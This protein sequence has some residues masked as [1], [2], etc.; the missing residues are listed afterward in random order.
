MP[1]ELRMDLRVP[2]ERAT[3][4]AEAR[5][6]AGL[7][8]LRKKQWSEVEA[9]GMQ[10]VERQFRV[11][12]SQSAKGVAE[13]HWT[14]PEATAHGTRFVTAE[15]AKIHAWLVA[16]GYEWHIYSLNHSETQPRAGGLLS[17]STDF[18]N[19][20]QELPVWRRF[21]RA[22]A[23]AAT[24]ARTGRAAPNEHRLATFKAAVK[25]RVLHKVSN[26]EIY[27][28]AGYSQKKEFYEWRRGKAGRGP[29]ERFDR[30]LTMSPEDFLKALKNR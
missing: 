9:A 12:S 5:F 13:G 23:R 22:L 6:K 20:F 10:T 7:L 15:A 21:L 26:A 17:F 11:L 24:P 1:R 3:A 27:R 16:H 25:S 14:I 4:L 29:S 30:V 18:T 19:A 28:V 2:V 8:G